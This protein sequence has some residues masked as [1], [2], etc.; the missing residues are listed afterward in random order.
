MPDP[1]RNRLK[2]Y[3]GVL[4]SVLLAALAGWVLWR[5][6]QRISFADV[7]AQ[8]RAMPASTLALAAPVRRGAFTVLA[9]Y[10]VA[11]VRYVKHCIGRAK[12]MVTAF[13]AFPLGHA[14]GQA[15]LSGGALRYRMYTP[16]GFSAT[17][18]GATVLLAN[19]PYALAFGLLLDISLVFAADTLEPMFR[20]SSE[21]LR[22]L[23][24]IG[25]CKDAGYVLLVVLRKNPCKLGGWAV[26]LP[27]PA[28]TALQLRASG[29]PTS[30]SSR[31][32]CTCCCRNRSG[33]A[34]LPFL[35]AYLASV[36]AG[37]L[38]H[39]P[40]GLGVLE[41]ML[42]LLLPDVPPEQLLAA[43]L[44][45]RVIYEIVPVLLAL[46]LWGTFEG[47]SRDGVLLR[48]VRPSGASH[49][50]RREPDHRQRASERGCGRSR[51]RPRRAA[52]CTSRRRRP[53]PFLRRRGTAGPA[54]ARP[55]RGASDARRW[56]TGAGSL[57]PM[58][59]RTPA[60]AAARLPPRRV[61]G[62]ARDQPDDA[63]TTQ[64]CGCA[65]P[66]RL[67]RIAGRPDDRALGP[68]PRV[69]ANVDRRVEGE[70][71]GPAR[72]HPH[73]GEVL[74]RAAMRA[75]QRMRLRRRHGDR[76]GAK[77]HVLPA[78]VGLQ[79]PAALARDEF[80]DGDAALDVDVARERP[81]QRAHAWLADPPV[82]DRCGPARSSSMM[83]GRQASST[84]ARNGGFRVTA[85][86]AAACRHEL[87]AVI[88]R[89]LP[90]A[91]R[92]Q[93]AAEAARSLE[94][95]D[96]GIGPRELVGAGQPRHAGADHRKPHVIHRS[97]LLE[98]CVRGAAPL[99][100]PPVQSR[101]VAAAGQGQGR[102]LLRSEAGL[103]FAQNHRPQESHKAGLP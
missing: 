57:R 67:A 88:E 19:M 45:Y 56:C 46:A 84:P 76:D 16:A 97:G 90:D 87:R 9:C 95:R 1:R 30:S 74:E 35:A 85:E 53:Q 92:G 86:R 22:V 7:L 28:M 73:V 58:R 38:S 47:F 18:V 80:V 81:H 52:R 4:V 43:V 36:L 60:A 15:M 62:A 8:M 66:F 96:L 91:T 23:G 78:G 63:C 39:V 82:F 89:E 34:Y 48:A 29:S 17:E 70:H 102:W 49:H 26:N 32:S 75:Q 103:Q 10:E 54:A 31:R 93:A 79:L 65:R 24:C 61:R 77:S 99:P 94:H 41:S 69:R 25:L 50:A 3:V 55:A 12:P 14:V 64:H 20:V 72:R 101:M 51:R 11:V 6:F 68:A 71:A 21:W 33:I 59:P 98:R 2:T 40:A 5:T 37:V 27:T 42:L 100:A 44:M 13:I 83:R